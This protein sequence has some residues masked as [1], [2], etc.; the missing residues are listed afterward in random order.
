ME[1]T[2]KGNH[3]ERIEEEPRQDIWGIR[4]CLDSEDEPNDIAFTNE[5]VG[6]KIQGTLIRIA[7]ILFG[8]GHPESW[9][10]RQMVVA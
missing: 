6:V 7:F 2:G 9:S 10:M 1:A 3:R 8:Q 4:S 5:G